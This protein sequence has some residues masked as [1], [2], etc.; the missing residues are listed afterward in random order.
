MENHINIFIVSKALG[1]YR[2]ERLRAGESRI[3][4]RPTSGTTIF[5]GDCRVCFRPRIQPR[6]AANK[7]L[8][9]HAGA[10]ERESR[11]LIHEF[12]CENLWWLRAREEKR[13]RTNREIR[14]EARALTSLARVYFPRET[15]KGNLFP[16]CFHDCLPPSLFS[17]APGSFGES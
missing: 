10:A 11:T 2:F 13:D 5:G 17:P 16:G 12:R 6:P 3:R 4:K 1:I 15:I 9:H 14:G 8:V 7:S